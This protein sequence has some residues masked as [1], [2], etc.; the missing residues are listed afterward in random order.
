MYGLNDKA[1]IWVVDDDK[2]IRWV[3]DKAL[4]KARLP[5]R[6]FADGQEVIDALEHW[7]NQSSTIRQPGDYPALLLSDIKMPN[8]SGIT[9][10]RE[11]KK[12]A[13]DIPVVM[14]T[15]HADLDNAVSTFQEGAVEYIAKPFDTEEL[16][17]LLK[18]LLYKPQ[19]NTAHFDMASEQQRYGI[20]GQNPAILNI[21][22]TIGRLANSDAS[23]LL[24][25]ETGTGK[26][27]VARAIHTTCS[28]NKNPF[29]AINTASIPENLL[30][31]EL[32]GHEK[33]AFIGADTTRVGRFEEAEGGTLF[34]DEIGDMPLT[35]QARL[36]RVLSEGTF[37]RTGGNVLIHTNARIIATTHQNLAQRISQGLFRADLY[38]RINVVGI[39][40]PALRDRVDDI[41]LLMQH[42]LQKA[43]SELGLSI[44]KSLSH[45][46]Q[47]VCQNAFW[48][49]NVRQ[50]E[51]I[52]RWLTIMTSTSLINE[53]DLPA[54][55]HERKTHTSLEKESSHTEPQG[56][57]WQD[58]LRVAVH[59][60]L[61]QKQPAVMVKMQNQFE[62][63][64]INE[65]LKFTKNHRQKAALLLGIG[66]NTITRK[67][68]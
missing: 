67:M 60:A 7:K 34:L 57:S 11:F 63:A 42:F 21:L 8:M 44:S 33:G 6:M 68:V 59:Q 48:S 65:A 46:A 5:Y 3:L 38:H 10:L 12:Q 26:E 18:R 25:G 9:L 20:L 13:P 30:E 49:G 41:P 27:L 50:L 15:A 23:I 22:R 16:I 43:A 31:S 51:N 55:I 14:M 56:S 24:T 66:R 58:A 2:S 36:L 29:V 37:Y 28:R 39:H 54:E 64:V 17:A 32:F 4:Y 53:A 52:C 40:L 35:L 47:V 1:T 19:V 62:Q 61:S 45:N